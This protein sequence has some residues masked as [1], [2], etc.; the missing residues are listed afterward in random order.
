LFQCFAAKYQ[1]AFTPAKFSGYIGGI[2]FGDIF[3]C[4]TQQDFLS[5]GNS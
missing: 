1:I 3:L 4:A 2:Y 5:A